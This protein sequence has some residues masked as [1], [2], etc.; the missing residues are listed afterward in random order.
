MLQF[1]R[2]VLIAFSGALWMAVGLYLL[3][4][5]IRF[6]LT[7]AQANGEGYYLFQGLSALGINSEQ[8]A[9]VLL[10]MGLAVGYAKAKTVLAKTVKKGVER[11]QQLPAKASLAAIYTPKYLLLI[12]FMVLLGLSLKWFAVP[13]DIRGFVDVT[14]GAA[15]INGA[16][17]YFR[18]SYALVK[19]D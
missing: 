7:A 9:L 14:I 4:L 17:L 8:A 12:G 6:L 13:L 15:L 5:G 3:P 1:S 10:A 16:M 19:T 11:I 18:N 2:P